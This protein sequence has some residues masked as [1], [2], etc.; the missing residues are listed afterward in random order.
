[1]VKADLF[2]AAFIQLSFRFSPKISILYDFAA[3]FTANKWLRSASIHCDVALCC[4]A[5][6]LQTLYL[7]ILRLSLIALLLN[8]LHLS[9]ISS[10]Y[11]AQLH[12]QVLKATGWIDQT[13]WKT[14]W[15]QQ[16]RLLPSYTDSWMVACGTKKIVKIQQHYGRQDVKVWQGG[17]FV[18]FDQ[19]WS[20]GLWKS[21]AQMFR[22][23]SF[24]RRRPVLDFLPISLKARFSVL[25]F[26][27][28]RFCILCLWVHSATNMP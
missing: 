9:V 22:W 12:W 20:H 15:R 13:I 11:S 16:L 25:S 24:R 14:F 28:R 10:I 6:Q 3:S 21:E 17:D 26:N 18:K 27:M 8:A 1:M 2:L 19:I 23:S 7:P 4:L 5:P